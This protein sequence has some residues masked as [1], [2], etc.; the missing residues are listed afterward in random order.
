[1]SMPVRERTDLDVLCELLP[2]LGLD[3]ADVGCGS[4]QLV[5]ALAERGARAIG[6]EIS[7][8]QL[9]AAQAAAPVPGAEYVVGRAEALGLADATLDAVVFMRSLHHVAAAE[10]LAAL[11]EARRVL[12][13]NGRLYVAEPLA[14]GDLYQLTRMVENEDDERAAAQATIAAAAHGGFA[15][16]A[17]CRYDVVSVFADVEAFRRMTVSV[18]PARA[19]VYARRAEEIASRFSGLGEPVPGGGR[20]LRLPMKADLL[21]PTAG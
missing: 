3:I 11:A 21:A 14:E 17:S 16:V 6:I 20:R 8:D 1:M 18:D 9:A 15:L 10:H 7:D 2:P 4:G 5:R 13:P 19:A 12:R